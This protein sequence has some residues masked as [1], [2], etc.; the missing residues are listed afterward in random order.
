VFGR[1][2]T[3]PEPLAVTE[4]GE[5]VP[6]FT[7]GL[8]STEPARVTL[9]L[10]FDLTTDADR[11]AFETLQDDEEARTDVRNRFRDRMGAVADNA[12][13]RVDQDM[14]VSEAGISLATSPDGDTGIVTLSVAWTDLAGRA[15]GEPPNLVITEPFAS[16]FTPSREF[17]VRVLAPDNY[18][19]T[20]A[21]PEPMEQTET[22]AS[23]AAGTSLN[24][25]LLEFAPEGG[26]PLPSDALEAFEPASPAPETSDGGGGP[27]SATLT[28][29]GLL[30]IAIAAGGYLAWR[31]RG[32][33]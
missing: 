16:G 7:V 1:P 22:S 8:R 13:R 28:V 6:L 19:L 9:R 18:R 33:S 4:S 15:D 31:R 30:A 5:D 26:T 29:G 10:T 3:G 2:S 17:T 24:D 27:S 32:E 11:R 25:F 21:N 14:S 12:E 23:W 20:R